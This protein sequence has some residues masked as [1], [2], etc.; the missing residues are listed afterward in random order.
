MVCETLA[1]GR[2]CTCTCSSERCCVAGLKGGWTYTHAKLE[3]ATSIAI[4]CAGESHRCFETMIYFGCFLGDVGARSYRKELPPNLTSVVVGI[5]QGFKDEKKE[6][7]NLEDE[8]RAHAL[9]A[10]KGVWLP[11]TLKS[12]PQGRLSGRSTKGSEPK[13]SA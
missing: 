5:L 7:Q 4:P 8:G 2:M 11:C 9:C 6:E 13:P 1:A 3:G 12:T 10:E